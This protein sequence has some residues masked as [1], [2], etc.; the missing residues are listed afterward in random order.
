MSFRALNTLHLR[1]PAFLDMFSSAL[2]ILN[3]AKLPISIS[4]QEK[5]VGGQ[6]EDL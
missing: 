1:Y 6:E 2:H 5:I 4:Y 3:L